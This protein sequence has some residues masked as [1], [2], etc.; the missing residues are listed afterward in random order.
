MLNLSNI[1]H[2]LSVALIVTGLSLLAMG[3]EKLGSFLLMDLGLFI[4]LAA[5]T[6]AINEQDS[7]KQ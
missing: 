2:A 4:E 5:I 7:K 6:L 1:R 3:G